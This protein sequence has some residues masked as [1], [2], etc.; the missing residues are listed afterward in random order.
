MARNVSIV[1]TVFNLALVPRQSGAVVPSSWCWGQR[2]LEP[3][4]AGV[5][6]VILAWE[7]RHPLFVKVDH[8]RM[9]PR[10]WLGNGN[11]HPVEKV[12]AFQPTG[13]ALIAVRSTDSC[14]ASV[15]CVAT[16][17]ASALPMTL[18]HTAAGL[19]VYDGTR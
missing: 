18:L 19:F 6:T 4:T 16:V 7:T 17:G 9:L 3:E 12:L 2:A 13:T 1:V 5:S 14:C 11:E 10:G 8:P 15:V